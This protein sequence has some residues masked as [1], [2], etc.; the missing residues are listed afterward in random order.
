[1]IGALGLAIVISYGAT[2]V[3]SG[4]L[5]TGDVV[6][7]F[8]YATNL[9]RPVRA[10]GRS[11][12]LYNRAVVAAERIIE[13]M[14]VQSELNDRPAAQAAPQLRGEIQFRQ[15]SFEYTT[16]HPILSHLDLAIAPGERVAI[17]GGTGAGKST[18]VSLVMRFYD[19]THGAVF[20][21]GRDI[22]NYK[23]RSLREQVSLVLQDSLLF[24]GTIRE[25]IAFGCPDASDDR[26]AAAARIA[27]ADE[28]IQRLPHRYD[29]VVRNGRPRSP[30][31]RSRELPSREPYCAMPPS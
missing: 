30:A 14:N 18:L 12:I 1:M 11:S 19:P 27:N 7:F 28:F 5:T 8:A 23:L 10:L 17:V 20:I 31:V 6:I 16:G 24:N 3:L 29:A 21:D 22:R 9:F 15:V 26:I 13:V 2:S 25:N 4:R